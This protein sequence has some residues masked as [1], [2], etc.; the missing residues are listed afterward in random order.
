MRLHELANE[1]E[2]L[3]LIMKIGLADLHQH[4]TNNLED[5]ADVT[6]TI[7]KLKSG[8]FRDVDGKLVIK[9]MKN[10]NGIIMV[11]NER[12]L[13]YHVGDHNV[14]LMAPGENGLKI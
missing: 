9:K 7:E 12:I 4:V 14:K 6:V 11:E 1:N 5:L 3:S 8:E 10:E 2:H 13:L